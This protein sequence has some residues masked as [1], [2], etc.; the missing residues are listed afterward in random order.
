MKTDNW[1]LY[2]WFE[3]HGT[4]LVHPEDLDRF[5]RLSP[6]GKVFEKVGDD[7]DFVV[8]LAGHDTFRVKPDLMTTV[9]PPAFGYGQQAT[10]RSKGTVGTVADIRWHHAQRRPF[11]HLEVNGKRIASRYWAEDLAGDE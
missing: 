11:F 10:V 8:L 5:R 6:Y 1:V 4:A 2:P 7:G 3:E 9:E